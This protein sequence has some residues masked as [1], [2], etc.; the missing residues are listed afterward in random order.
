M[1]KDIEREA[2]E[3]TQNTKVLFERIEYIA[4]MDAYMPKH[5]F[6]NNLIVMQAAERFNFGWSMWKSATERAEKKLEGC[7]VAPEW[8]STR[9][10]LPEEGVEVLVHRYGQIIQ[11]TKDK[12]YA[13]GFK[14][15]NCYGWQ[16]T[17][18]VTYW[19]PKNFKLPDG[20]SFYYNDEHPYRET[21]IEA[22]RGG[23]E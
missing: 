12:G 22:A 10:Y 17:F 4:S 13:G 23:N 14:E 18:D 8:I 9:D 3:A 7:V 20:Y 19:M 11:A 16:A 15:R 6:T 1:T 2:F 21:M 5:E